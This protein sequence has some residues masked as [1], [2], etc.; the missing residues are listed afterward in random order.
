[1]AGIR[2]QTH[3]DLLDAAWADRPG[4]PTA[5]VQDH[6]APQASVG[7]PATLAMVRDAMARHGATHHFVSSVDDIAWITNLRGSDV[8]YNPVF[9]AH[10]LIDHQRATLFVGAGKVSPALA[11]ALAVD[12]ITLADYDQAA[13]ALGALSPDSR[14][15]IDPKR[16]T[17]GLREAAPGGLPVIEAINPSTL[18][19][20]R[21]GPAEAAFIRQ[22]MEEDGA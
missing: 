13:A 3:G 18:M 8:E 1:R 7:R 19:K 2:L 9:L 5:A 16:V 6:V 12:G 4:L 11:A 20:S 14:L 10:L 22:A 17:L 15:L 21:K